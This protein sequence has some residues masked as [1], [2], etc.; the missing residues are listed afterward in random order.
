VDRRTL[1]AVVSVIVSAVLTA[2]ATFSGD[3]DHQTR[4]YLVVLAVTL[5]AAAI[6]FWIVVPRVEGSGVAALVL[7][8][9]S[10]VS[11]GVFWLGLPAVFAGTAA[12]LALDAREGPEDRPALT[13]PALVIA[14]VVVVLAAVLA[15]AG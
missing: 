11:L 9:L 4:E 7:A 5:V 2:I 1:F 6:L 3:D 12:L 15:F 10:F 14:A 13:I 8:V